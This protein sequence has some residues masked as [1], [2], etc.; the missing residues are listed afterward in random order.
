MVCVCVCVYL[1]YLTAMIEMFSLII[2]LKVFMQSYSYVF[3]TICCFQPKMLFFIIQILSFK[4][5]LVNFTGELS[6]SCI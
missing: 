1:L 3:I 4:Y 5:G 2:Y 6:F